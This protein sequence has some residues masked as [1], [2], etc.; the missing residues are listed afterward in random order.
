MATTQRTEPSRTPAASKPA[1]AERISGVV[2]AVSATGVQI[3][4]VWYDWPPLWT[5]IK[6]AVGDTVWLT[7]R[8][9]RQVLALT[10]ANGRSPSASTG[11]S[12][13][14]PA[15]SP[16][17]RP[18]VSGPSSGPSNG[19]R[20]RPA[21]SSASDRRTV[22]TGRITAANVRGIRVA[23]TWYNYSRFTPVDESTKAQLVPGVEVRCEI[24][25]DRWIAAASI[26]APASD[27]HHEAPADLPN[28]EEY[29]ERYL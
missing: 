17:S 21:S 28:E 29:D 2:E 7:Y 18:P 22:V 10:P 20:T 13:N 5:G 14:R 1:E 15:P 9:R 19:S 26:L 23:E 4:Q 3:A 12:V 24:D 11:T 27:P 8:L 16:A 25:N 6:P